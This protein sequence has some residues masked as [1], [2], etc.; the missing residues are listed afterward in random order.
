MAA[1]R[2]VGASEGRLGAILAEGEIFLRAILA[3]GEIFL[4]S[5]GTCKDGLAGGAGGVISR[6]QIGDASG[7]GVNILIYTHNIND[8][9]GMI[10]SLVALCTHPM[11]PARPDQSP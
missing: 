4:R 1:N 11:H 2:R 5:P 8:L 6:F 3:G 9:A 7:H 10:A